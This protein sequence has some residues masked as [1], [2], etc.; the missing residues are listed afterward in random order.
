MAVRKN[1]TSRF[2]A[3]TKLTG[4]FFWNGICSL[5]V[6]DHHGVYLLHRESAI[7]IIR[8]IHLVADPKFRMVSV[9]EHRY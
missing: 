3:G 6:Y 9:C 8:N 5:L 2:V 4:S 7:E 1:L